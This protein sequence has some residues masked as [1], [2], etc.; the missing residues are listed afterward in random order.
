M[1]ALPASEPTS[2][3]P[4]VVRC[5][6][7]KYSPNLGDGLLS[8]CLEFALI[9][10]G[11]A[12]A[13]RSI[14]LAA[15]TKYGDAMLGRGAALKAL[16]AMPKALRQAAV[17][18]P[19]FMK[20]V[21][22]WRPHFAAGLEGAQAVALGGGNLISDL[23]LNFPTKLGL[24]ITEAEKRKLPIAIYACGM[25]SHWSPLGL[26]WLRKAFSSPY[27]RAVFVRDA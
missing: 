23:D 11:A 7:V 14:D 25:G 12:K 18:A 5:F 17:R 1:T 2:A 16:D 27:M 20:S 3:R 19:L 15:R 22:E 13:T 9:D 26:R 6:N 4:L 24:A 8:E 10:H 21:T